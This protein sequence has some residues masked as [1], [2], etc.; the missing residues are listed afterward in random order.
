MAEQGYEPGPASVKTHAFCDLCTKLW[1]HGDLHQVGRNTWRCSSHVPPLVPVLI[2]HL[3]FVAH[4]QKMASL[5]TFR[6]LTTCPL[7]AF[8]FFVCFRLFF[9]SW[10]KGMFNSVIISDEEFRFA[11]GSAASSI[12]TL[13]KLSISLKLSLLKCR[14]H[15]WMRLSMAASRSDN[16]F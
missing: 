8:S 9:N 4:H 2:L 15:R 13:D 5:L 12:Q 16:D 6:Q 3:Q 10:K 14:T 11:L 1:A 7:P